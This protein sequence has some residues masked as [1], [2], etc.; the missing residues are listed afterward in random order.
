[1]LL[2]LLD[3]NTTNLSSEKPSLMLCGTIQVGW[4]KTVCYT[5]KQVKVSVYLELSKNYEKQR[6]SRISI[7]QV[8]RNGTGMVLTFYKIMNERHT[9]ISGEKNPIDYLLASSKQHS[10]KQTIFCQNSGRSF[11]GYLTQI[12]L[13]LCVKTVQAVNWIIL[14]AIKVAR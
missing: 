5:S 7:V 14:K 3:K 2:R 11:F 6:F 8:E 1:M 4:S 9:G 13:E 12:L 10:R